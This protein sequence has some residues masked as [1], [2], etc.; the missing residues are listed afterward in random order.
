M[1]SIHGCKHKAQKTL[2]YAFN[3][4]HVNAP[5]RDCSLNLLSEQCHHIG[6]LDSYG[7][8]VMEIASYFP[9]NALLQGEFQQVQL[10]ISQITSCTC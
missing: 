8:L 10:V 1:N 5:K 2:G 4:V 3:V 9:G 6:S 7:G